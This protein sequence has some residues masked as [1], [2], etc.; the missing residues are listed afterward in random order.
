MD[1]D[2]VGGDC[3]WGWRTE[4]GMEN[5]A[6]RQC[7]G[8]KFEMHAVRRKRKKSVASYY[9]V[10]KFALVV[11]SPV[12]PAPR[13]AHTKNPGLDYA[14]SKG[15]TNFSKP[16]SR[17]KWLTLNSTSKIFPTYQNLKMLCLCS[18]MGVVCVLE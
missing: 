14:A 16:N 4:G 13:L 15:T 8:T 17:L 5:G 1:L 12:V 3:G 10:K 2:V 18:L 7:R 9:E 6:Q 11:L